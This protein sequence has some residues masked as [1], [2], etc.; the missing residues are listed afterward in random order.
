M[1]VPRGRSAATNIL[2]QGPPTARA[3]SAS[4]DGRLAGEVALVTGC[5]GGIGRATALLYAQEGAAV[6]ATDVDE[7]GGRE[8]QRLIEEAGGQCIFQRCV[9]TYLCQ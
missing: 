2:R 9:S 7:D 4:G 6:V 3:F 1:S 5:A 8:T